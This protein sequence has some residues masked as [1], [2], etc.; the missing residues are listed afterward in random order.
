MRNPTNEYRTET[1]HKHA[2]TCTSAALALMSFS[3]IPS[4]VPTWSPPSWIVTVW[5]LRPL[6]MP[7]RRRSCSCRCGERGRE[8]LLRNRE[9]GRKCEK[10]GFLDL[11]CEKFVL[12]D[13]QLE[14]CRPDVRERKMGTRR[15]RTPAPIANTGKQGRSQRKQ[16]KRGA[17]AAK[18]TRLIVH[19]ETRR[20]LNRSR[21][22]KSKKR[23]S[24]RA[25]ATA[26]EIETDGNKRSLFDQNW[27]DRRGGIVSRKKA[28]QQVSVYAPKKEKLKKKH[29]SGNR[30]Q[31][32]T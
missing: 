24:T 19:F 8:R 1:H 29:Q 3:T 28:D 20:S 10:C 23:K 15:T 6:L 5:D 13:D 11:L 26:T 7:R 4:G 2:A 21:I 14:E 18:K 27:E 12:V 17:V 22:N 9:L 31:V 16:R 30:N 25:T 32:K